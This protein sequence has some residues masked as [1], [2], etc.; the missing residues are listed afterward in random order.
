MIQRLVGTSRNYPKNSFVTNYAIVVENTKNVATAD[1]IK[2]AKQ[3]NG[4]IWSSIAAHK[5]FW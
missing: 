3:V 1:I 4:A 5:S 2:R